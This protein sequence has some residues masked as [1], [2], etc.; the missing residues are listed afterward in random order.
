M[1]CKEV[2]D[3]KTIWET[4]G[5]GKTK[6][7]K[8]IR[9][10]ESRFDEVMTRCA[11]SFHIEHLCTWALPESLELSAVAG[12]YSFGTWFTEAHIEIRGDDSIAAMP[13]GKK[14]FIYA[15]GITASRWLLK[16]IVVIPSFIALAC[17][18]PPKEWKEKLFFCMPK[19]T[20]AI[21]QPSFWAHSVMTIQ[22]PAQVISWEAGVRNKHNR[23]KTVQYSF[24]RG[25]GMEAQNAIR[26]MTSDEQ[27]KILP[28]LPGDARDCMRAQAEAGLL[29]PGPSKRSR[30]KKRFEYLPGPKKR[31]EKKLHELQGW[32]SNFF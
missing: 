6:E 15:A 27:D 17:N 24:A 8:R 25:I 19:A 9:V 1:N 3:V 12:I 18:G 23:L 32:R 4:R 5:N 14:V 21:A 7:G 28:S 11:V 20:S 10:I 30:K 26:Q 16:S 22:G 2:R 29:I 13:L 31:K